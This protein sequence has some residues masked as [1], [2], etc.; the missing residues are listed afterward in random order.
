MPEINQFQYARGDTSLLQRM[1]ISVD[2]YII[3]RMYFKIYDF[4]WKIKVDHFERPQ[5]Y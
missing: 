4:I 2:R 1:S 3:S 5:K